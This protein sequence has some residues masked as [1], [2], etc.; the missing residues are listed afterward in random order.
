MPGLGEGPEDLAQHVGDEDPLLF[1]LGAAHGVAGFGRGT[2]SAF[3]VW[4]MAEAV[5]GKQV[6]AEAVFGGEAGPE[7]AAADFFLDGGTIGVRT[8]GTSWH[9]FF[10]FRRTGFGKCGNGIHPL[11]EAALAAANPLVRC[12]SDGGRQWPGDR[13]LS[14]HPKDGTAGWGRR[15]TAARILFI[16]LILFS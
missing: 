2:G 11:R 13:G 6:R 1:E 5:D 12:T 14:C 16:S 15:R 8:N 4:H 9:S 7:D 3:A 10:L